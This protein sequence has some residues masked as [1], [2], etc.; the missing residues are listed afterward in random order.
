M[1]DWD[2]YT[3]CSKRFDMPDHVIKSRDALAEASTLDLAEAFKLTEL[4]ET[5]L[6]SDL[7]MVYDACYTEFTAPLVEALEFYADQLHVIKDQDGKIKAED[8]SHARA[9][10]A[11]HRGEG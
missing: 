6:L 7:K 1:S 2:E 3:N 8:G 5:Q 11:K 10:L 9:A 4:Q